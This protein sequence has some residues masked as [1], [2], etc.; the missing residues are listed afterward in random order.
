MENFERSITSIRLG[1][2]FLHGLGLTLTLYP[3][4]YSNS[5]HTVVR[6]SIEFGLVIIINI[7]LGVISVLP[8]LRKT[9]SHTRKGPARAFTAAIDLSL[10]VVLLVLHHDNIWVAEQ[11]WR[12]GNDVVLVYAAV[13]ALVAG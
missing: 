6:R 5:I 2:F 13:L 1:L 9:H 12:V 8:A 11:G 7:T 10:A 4:A 3:L